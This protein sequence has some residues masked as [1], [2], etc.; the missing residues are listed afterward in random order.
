MNIWYYSTE[1][2]PIFNEAIDK[3]SA[4]DHIIKLGIEQ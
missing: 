1:G 3:L 2:N 4:W